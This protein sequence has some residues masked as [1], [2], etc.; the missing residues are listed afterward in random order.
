MGLAISK[1]LKRHTILNDESRPLTD[2]TGDRAADRI[3]MKGLTGFRVDSKWGLMSRGLTEGVYVSQDYTKAKAAN[4]WVRNSCGTVFKVE[5]NS[6]M[7][8][9]TDA[10]EDDGSF[11]DDVSKSGC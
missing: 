1:F 4:P 11:R 7:I 2:F 5:I 8:K 9:V 3:K 10:A 6:G